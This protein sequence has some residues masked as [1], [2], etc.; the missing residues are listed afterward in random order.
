MPLFRRGLRD[1]LG[2]AESATKMPRAVKR[3]I[4]VRQGAKMVDQ[5]AETGRDTVRL[6]NRSAILRSCH[7][8]QIES[9][10][11]LP[12]SAHRAGKPPL[13]MVDSLRAEHGRAR[14]LG[15]P[16]PSRRRCGITSCLVGRIRT[17]SPLLARGYL[18]IVTTRQLRPNR[19]DS[20]GSGARGSVRPRPGRLQQCP[21]WT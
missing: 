13:V 2:K 7:G 5:R 16:R 17:I 8:L 15:R 9:G 21:W 19:R 1:R 11:G 14:P 18:S 4:A 3:A 20:K 6:V 12:R 10:E